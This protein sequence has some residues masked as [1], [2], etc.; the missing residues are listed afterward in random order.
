MTT[1]HRLRYFV[2]FVLIMQQQ[3]KKLPFAGNNGTEYAAHLNKN[4]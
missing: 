4:M 1:K 3:L 2:L